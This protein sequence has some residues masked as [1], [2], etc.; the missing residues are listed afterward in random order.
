MGSINYRSSIPR[1]SSQVVFAN[2]LAAATSNVFYV[3]SP[4]KIIHAISRGA[5]STGVIIDV[6]GNSLE[7]TTDGALIGSILLQSSA[8]LFSDFLFFEDVWPF[9]YMKISGTFSSPI[10]VNLIS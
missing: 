10:D 7:N 2:A 3:P 8:S 5:N 1:D 4:Q 6:Y 9:M